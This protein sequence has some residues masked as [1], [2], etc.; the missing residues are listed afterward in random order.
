MSNVRLVKLVSGEEV[1]FRGGECAISGAITMKNPITLHV[2]P[3]GQEQ[4]GLQLFPYSPSC[5]DGDHVLYLAQV[6]SECK[7]VPDGLVKAY[8]QRTTGI[9]IA[10]AVDAF[11]NLR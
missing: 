7:D 9:E 2:V 3:Q 6:V 4:Y 8:I 1:I 5:P 11:A 10:S